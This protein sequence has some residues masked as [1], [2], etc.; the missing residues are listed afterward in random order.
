MEK[1]QKTGRNIGF[2]L[3]LI[4]LIGI[5]SVMFRGLSTSLPDS[6][7]FLSQIFEN[8]MEMRVAILLDILVCVLWV[9][10]ATIIFQLIKKFNRRLAIGFF[11]IWMTYSAII[12]FSNISHLSLLSLSQEFVNVQV[13]NAEY[14]MIAGR[15]K[16][17]DYFWAHFFG[18]MLY[19]TAAFI[20][21]YFL[22]KNRLVPRLL[23]GWGM[24][25]ISIVFVACWLNIFD[26]NVSFHFFSQNGIHMIVLTG[27]L[28]AKGFA[29]NPINPNHSIK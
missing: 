7:N 6:P 28:I 18:I 24:I 23:S 21:Y 16:V 4:M 3:L 26:L 1:N 25:A 9:V 10:I 13:V 8:A 15:L 22:F 14:F 17:E 29:K 5:P 12:I 27:W 2:L 20:F 19:A 11:G